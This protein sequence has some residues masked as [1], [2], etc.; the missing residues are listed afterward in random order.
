MLGAEASQPAS[1]TTTA[2]T[3]GGASTSD[4][5]GQDTNQA[6]SASTDQSKPD[7]T[8]SASSDKLSSQ[9]FGGGPIVGVASTSK[10]QS[11]RE[12]NHKNHY[13]KWQFIYDPTMD[14]GGLIKTPA[15]PALQVT[16][17]IQQ[18]NPSNSPGG[19][20]GSSPPPAQPTQQQPQRMSLRV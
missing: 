9:V 1:A 17:P 14:R 3:S 10:A 19:L 15:Q 5:S 16:A 4:N 7:Q 13:D 8:Q 20:Q 6:N 2:N 12:F 18:Q 11:I